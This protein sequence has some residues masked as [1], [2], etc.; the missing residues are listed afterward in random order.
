MTIMQ[1]AE[2]LSHVQAADA[3]PAR[4]NWK[5]ALALDLTDP[6]FD[7]SVLSEFRQ[8]LIAGNAELLLFE[9][10]LTLLRGRR[11]IKAKG[12]QRTDSTSWP[13]SRRSNVWMASAKRSAMRL[14]RWPRQMGTASQL[15]GAISEPAM[16]AWLREIPA[17]QTLRQV[18]LQQWQHLRCPFLL[19]A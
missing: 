1:F 4:I 11:L 12:R 3:V 15:L 5:Y 7:A 18:W 17:I 2:G 8:R 14:T 13:P 10:T 6:G 9:T 19:P 16:P